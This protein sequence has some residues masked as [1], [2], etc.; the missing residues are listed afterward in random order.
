MKIRK[1][2][3]SILNVIPVNII[4]VYMFFLATHEWQDQEAVKNQ[5]TFWGLS[6]SF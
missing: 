5:G 1:E 6:E 4:N 2:K 3:I